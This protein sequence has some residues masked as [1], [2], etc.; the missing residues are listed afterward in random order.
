MAQATFGAGR[1]WSVEVAFR[2]VPSMIDATVG[3]AGGPVADP[4]YQQ[5]CTDRTRH[6]AVVQVEYDPAQ[7]GYERLLEVF[8]ANHDP[9]PAQSPGTGRCHPVP[10]RGFYHDETQAQARPR[11]EGALQPPV[12]IVARGDR[13]RALLEFLPGG[14]I[15]PALPGKARARQVRHALT[16]I[17]RRPD[18]AFG[19]VVLP[20]SA[21]RPSVR[22]RGSPAHRVACSERPPA[23]S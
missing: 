3:S 2:Q 21:R 11:S 13:D 8:F 4:S 22:S 6:A 10:L 23:G 16:R 19:A 1:F 12:G 5:M 7:V 18:D 17:A 14:R 9:D 20:G 15:P